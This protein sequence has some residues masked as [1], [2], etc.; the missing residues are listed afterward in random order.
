LK[1]TKLTKLNNVGK[2]ATS[3]VATLVV[4]AVLALITFIGYREQANIYDYLKLR[5]YN[6]P[7]TIAALA[8]S[9]TMTSYGRKI[10]YVNHPQVTQKNNFSNF[11]PNG[12]EQTVVLGCYHSYENGINILSV[13]NVELNGIEQVTSAH[14]MLHGAYEQLTMSD[15]NTLDQLLLNY[16]NNGLTDTTIKDQIASYKKTEPD[17]IVDEM[18]SLFGTQIA[19][20][21]PA[22]EK[23]YTRYFTT[24]QTVVNYYLS[25]QNAFTS[26]QNQIK[27]DDQT[28]SSLNDQISTNN[29]ILDNEYANIQS[30]Q[31]N[32][33]S[34]KNNGQNSQYNDGVV[35]FNTQVDSYNNL[36]A[37]TR[38]L[39]SQY[40]E[41]VN[42]RNALVLE[43]QQLTKALSSSN[44]TVAK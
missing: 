1:K 15:K 26:R 14:E 22:L 39:I 19:N 10:F 35:G 43:E 8:T 18:H 42:S 40:N 23:Y 24:R 11:C 34:Q 17:A 31:N 6:A 3:L 12:T 33:N 5:G 37:T 21:P 13:D 29:H 2:A 44:Q 4:V 25:Y 41:A 20:L 32:L 38:S 16:Y 30:L 7:T 36:V 28:L 9:D 27:S